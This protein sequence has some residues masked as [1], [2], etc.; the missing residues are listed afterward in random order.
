[1]AGITQVCGSKIWRCM[2]CVILPYASGA[3]QIL[4]NAQMSTKSFCP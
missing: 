2:I 3:V 1:M 4:R